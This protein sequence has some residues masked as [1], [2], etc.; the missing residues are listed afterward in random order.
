MVFET[1]A[2]TEADYYRITSETAIGKVV[3]Q[4]VLREVVFSYT[5]TEESPLE[6][7]TQQFVS[8]VVDDGED[9][10]NE[11]V[12]TVALLTAPSVRMEE[13]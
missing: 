13:V 1:P 3:L 10:S 4:N 11:Y 2:D 6:S 7:D 8:I 5:P 12:A 9:N